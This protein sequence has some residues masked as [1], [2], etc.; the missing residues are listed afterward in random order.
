[1]TGNR[2]RWHSR[3]VKIVALISIQTAWLAAPAVA[4]V[5]DSEQGQIRV[6]RVAGPFEHPWS[7]AWLPDGQQ[8]VTERDG[9]IVLLSPG[10]PRQ[11]SG[12]PEVYDSGQ[13]GLL[14][15]AVSPEYE[16]DGT[17]FLTYSEPVA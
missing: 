5:F 2:M 8:L 14:D 12:V 16:S 1:M 17:I 6:E 4:Q 9:R 7:V 11:V 13:G 3:L 10:G 15:V